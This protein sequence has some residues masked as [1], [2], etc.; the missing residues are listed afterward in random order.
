MCTLLILRRPK[1]KWPIILGSNRDEY[2][3]RLGLKPKKHWINY[4]N[5]FGGYDTKAHGSWLGINNNGLCAI[6]LNRKI[7]NNNNNNYLSSRGLLV[8][9]ALS[10]L[11][12]DE[13]K[14]YFENNKLI[15]Y[16]PFNL[17]IADKKSAYWLKYD[18]NSRLQIKNIPLGLS[19]IDAYDINDT[20]S[21]KY[22]Y[23]FK[24]L[25]NIVNPSPEKNKWDSWKSF[26]S[27]QN[28]END[29]KLSAIN[30][31]NKSLNFATV[32]SSIISL[33][34]EGLEKKNIK[35]KWLYCEGRPDKHKYD[36]LNLK[37]L[38]N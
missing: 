11:S 23:N 21:P 1:E 18:T 24:L 3:K 33:P 36:F 22:K 30:V 17:V 32:S 6:I 12:A 29:D 25:A 7:I 4:P 8:L 38:Y 2:I 16:R 34:S 15:N 20:T 19:M 31:F 9:K 5:I 26:L 10:F 37:T 35:P 13:S 27:S 28:Y 14:V